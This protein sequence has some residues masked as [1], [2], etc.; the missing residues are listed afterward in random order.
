METIAC[1]F[2]LKTKLEEILLPTLLPAAPVDGLLYNAERGFRERWINLFEEC[3]AV[4]CLGQDRQARHMSSLIKKGG[5]GHWASWGFATMDG[6]PDVYPSQGVSGPLFS[7]GTWLC[8]LGFFTT[9]LQIRDRKP[10]LGCV[11]ILASRSKEE[12]VGVLEKR[13]LGPGMETCAP[14]KGYRQTKQEIYTGPPHNLQGGLAASGSWALHPEDS[15]TRRRCSGHLPWIFISRRIASPVQPEP[16]AHPGRHLWEH[17]THQMCPREA[18]PGT[19]TTL[20]LPFSLP[21]SLGTKTLPEAR[22]WGLLSSAM[23][24]FSQSPREVQLAFTKTMQTGFENRWIY[25]ME[26]AMQHLLIR[27]KV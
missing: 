9:S 26:R 6:T 7:V 12:T 23:S 19:I 13:M 18:H 20:K 24:F 14:Q 25:T 22:I 15:A 3:P 8:K 16:S 27:K 17:R 5:C 4:Y 1:Y 10:S 21:V 2:D 11:I